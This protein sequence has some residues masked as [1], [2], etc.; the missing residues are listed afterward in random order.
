MNPTGAVPAAGSWQ[1]THQLLCLVC[2][3]SMQSGRM[4]PGTECQMHLVCQLSSH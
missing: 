2:A 3:G 1:Q 4:E